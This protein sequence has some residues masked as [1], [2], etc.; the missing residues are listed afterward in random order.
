VV[1]ISLEVEPL[2]ILGTLM[3]NSR[4]E[5]GSGEQG[6]EI[7]QQEIDIS[8]VYY[9]VSIESTPGSSILASTLPPY[10]KQP[11]PEPFGHTKEVQEPSLEH[12]Y[13]VR[14]LGNTL[15]WGEQ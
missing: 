9:H 15:T 2:D 1:E 7:T 12:I 11:D 4:D 14:S 8:R 3:D 10:E 6:E 5:I 13:I